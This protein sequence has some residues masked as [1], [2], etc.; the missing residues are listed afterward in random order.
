MRTT[1]VIPTYNERENLRP[2]IER[3]AALRIPN[4][5]ILIVDDNSPDG[6]GEIAEEISRRFQIPDSRFQIHVLH[7]SRKEGLG[8]AYLA[9]FQRALADGADVIVQMDADGSH[10]AGEIPGM[11]ALLASP[12]SFRAPPSSFRAKSEESHTN[13]RASHDVISLDS[14]RDDERVGTDLVIGS[15]RVRGGRVVGLGLHRCLASWAA[16]A[17]S[18]TSL[19]FQTHDVTSGFRSWKA[20]GLAGIIAYPPPQPPLP[21]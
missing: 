3:I 8:A 16:Q 4:I 9:G 5:A 21:T 19:G 12:S 13:A 11:I 14:A 10:D 6:T 2:L 1:I 17:L 18:R 20:A 7:R 15:R